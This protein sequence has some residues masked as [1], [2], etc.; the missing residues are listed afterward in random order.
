VRKPTFI[1][2]GAVA[3]SAIGFLAV[4]WFVVAN[5]LGGEMRAI[6]AFEFGLILGVPLGGFAGAILGRWLARTR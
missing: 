2:V 4:A 5:R 6:P 1:F 3:G